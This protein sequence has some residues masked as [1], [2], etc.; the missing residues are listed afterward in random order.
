L[1]A[2]LH[3]SNRK[4]RLEISPGAAR[5]GPKEREALP[6]CSDTLSLI[7]P[8]SLTLL[9]LLQKASL[10]NSA[11]PVGWSLTGESGKECE[12][13]ISGE[14]GEGLPVWAEKLAPCPK[15]HWL[16]LQSCF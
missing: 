16:S 11:L 9:R 7:D 1:L 12:R 3:S 4:Q 13:K 6:P 10:S 15:G 14:V 5:A 2:G 8:P